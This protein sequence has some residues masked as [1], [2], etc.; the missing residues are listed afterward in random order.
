MVR[1]KENLDFI[2]NYSPLPNVNST[3]IF[4]LI[5]IPCNWKSIH[6]PHIIFRKRTFLRE[7]FFVLILREKLQG[8][9][10]IN[11]RTEEKCDKEAKIIEEKEKINLSFF[12]V[13]TCSNCLIES[14]VLFSFWRFIYDLSAESEKSMYFECVMWMF[15]G[16][17][18]DA[19]INLQIIEIRQICYYLVTLSDWS[20]SIS[21]VCNASKV[22]TG[23]NQKKKVS[24]LC[25]F[26]TL[27]LIW[28]RHVWN[29]K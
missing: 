23:I 29:R 22:N 11:R 26:S 6:S 21:F 8:V 12:I 27:A 9:K 2:I 20:W 16:V 3:I 19:T 10:N 14:F 5:K 17:S 13:D 7:N 18:S 15:I 1:L 24:N 28:A 25:K 4:Y